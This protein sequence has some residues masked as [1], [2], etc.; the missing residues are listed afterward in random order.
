MME[1]EGQNREGF[2]R[3]FVVTGIV[4]MVVAGGVALV[5]V[6]LHI[7]GGEVLRAGC[8]KRQQCTHQKHHK[9]YC[10]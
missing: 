1:I 8:P 6:S 3:S 7:A 4:D 5:M 10:N 2:F 9:R